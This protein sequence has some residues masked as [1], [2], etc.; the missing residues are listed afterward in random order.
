MDTV[1]G[2]IVHLLLKTIRETTEGFKFVA[3]PSDS[4]WLEVSAVGHGKWSSELN[5]TT[6]IV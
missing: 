4:K 2:R 3:D 1:T 6:A 5:E